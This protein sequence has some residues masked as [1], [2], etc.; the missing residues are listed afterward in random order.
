MVEFDIVLTKDKIPVVYHDFSICIQNPFNLDKYLDVSINQL[1]YNDIKQSKV[2][3]HK[4]LLNDDNDNGNI[5]NHI[6]KYTS[7]DM[8]PTLK[9]MCLGLNE[10]LGF[11]IE[12][13]Y[14]QDLEDNTN[15]VDKH[16]KWLN[17]N[18]YVDSILNYLFNNCKLDNNRNIIFSTFDPTICSM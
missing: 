13:K 4:I 16:I 14:P 5:I 9:E 3:S 6:N 10:N 11:N 17:R 7:I 2:Y 8:F 12:I 15:E 18:D 1:T